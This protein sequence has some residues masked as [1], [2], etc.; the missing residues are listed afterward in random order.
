MKQSMISM[1]CIIRVIILY[2]AALQV[3]FGSLMGIPQF[4]SVLGDQENQLVDRAFQTDHW[5][6]GWPLLSKESEPTAILIFLTNL[7]SS[8]KVSS[9]LASF[10]QFLAKF[11]SF[12]TMMSFTWRF[13]CGLSHL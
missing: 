5:L 8:G 4:S 10:R 1:S 12:R 13:P 2:L 3:L 7:S 11:S 9:T 6:V